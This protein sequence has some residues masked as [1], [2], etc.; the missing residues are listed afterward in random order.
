MESKQR[1]Y[2][3]HEVATMF[4]VANVTIYRWHADS[5]RGIGSFPLGIGRGKLRFSA[6][7]IER[8]IASQLNS[9]PQVNVASA[10]KQRRKAKVHKQHQASATKATLEKHRRNR[11]TK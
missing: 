11:K 9:P 6:D 7:E 4:R 5:K 3:V 8:Y 2:L 10:S 1:F